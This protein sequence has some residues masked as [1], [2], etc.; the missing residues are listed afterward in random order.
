MKAI[1]GFFGL[2]LSNEGE[3]HKNAI[4]LNSGRNA[5]EYIL[6]VNGYKK[7]YFPYFTCDVLLE[8]MKKLNIE[9]SFYSINNAFEPIFDYA[10]IMQNEAFLYTNYF[11]LKDD[12]IKNLSLNCQNLIIDN[13][14]SFFSKPLKGIDTFYSPRKYFGVPDGAYLYSQKEILL[15]LITETSFEKFEHLLR[16]IDESPED[17]YFSFQENEKRF[18]AKPLTEMSRLTEKV[19][20]SINYAEVSEKRNINF[21]Y[22][23]EELNEWNRLEFTF[24]NKM[25][26]MVYPFLINDS[27]LRDYLIKEKIYTSV[28]WK[29][30]L[31]WVSKESIEY[32]FSK[33][34]IHLPID[35]RYNFDD[36]KYIV[37][38]IKKFMLRR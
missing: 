36:M 4:K 18:E 35:Q 34:I 6:V 26:P 37:K 2:E 24:N 33:R 23:H 14:Q 8:P 27:D 3:F 12:F 22:L 21:E 1:G 32:N 38:K 20:C 10:N 7:V 15:K 13:A 5:F 16:R 9:V 11:G 29:N 31:N 17:A 25:V 30:V 28:Y 19:L